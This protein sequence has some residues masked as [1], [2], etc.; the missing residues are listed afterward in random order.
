[1]IVLKIMC[2]RMENMV[3]LD[4]VS[5][6]PYP[7]RRLREA[8]VLT[9]AKSWY[10][11]YFNTEENLDYRGPL[12][13][14]SYYGVTEMVEGERSEF[15]KWDETQETPFDNRRFLEQYCQDDVT[16]LRQA[17]RVFRR[18]FMQIGNL[19]VFLESITIASA[20]NKVLR[21]RFLQPD[22]VGLIP[23]EGYTCNK[24]YRK[25]AMMWLLHMEETDGVEKMH[26]REYKVHE[27]PHFTVDGFC[28]ETGTIYEFFGCYFHGNSVNRSVKSSPRVAIH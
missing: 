26:G 23:T 18:E 14:V 9:V 6:L 4:S 13:D 2:M 17:C 10:P 19:D 20:C 22:I 27:L 3:F 12:P 21:K 24:N 8:F 7:L 25:K 1:M 28:P 11:H 15:L 5:F 16:V